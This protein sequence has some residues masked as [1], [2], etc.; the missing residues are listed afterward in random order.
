VIDP[1]NNNKAE[2]YVGNLKWEMLV[3]EEHYEEVFA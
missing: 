3:E 2:R 1:T